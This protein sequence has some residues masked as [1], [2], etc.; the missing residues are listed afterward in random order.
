MVRMSGLNDKLIHR[1]KHAQHNP[2]LRPIETLS[3]VYTSGVKEELSKLAELMADVNPVEIVTAINHDAERDK[4]LEQAMQGK[5]TTPELRYNRALLEMLQQKQPTLAKVVPQLRLAMADLPHDPAGA[6][7]QKLIQAR[8]TNANLLLLAA[9]GIRRGSVTA[10][11]AAFIEIYGVPNRHLVK[12][13]QAIIEGQKATTDYVVHDAALLSRDEQKRLMAIKL[14]AEAVRRIFLWAAEQYGL[15]QTRPVLI[16]EG[17]TA[18]D[19]RDTA[20]DG[21]C[22]VIPANYEKPA[23]KIPQLV[24]HEIGCHWRDSENMKSLVPMLGSGALKPFDELFYEGHAVEAEYAI[25]LRAKGVVKDTLRLCYPIAI[26]LAYHNQF[27]FEETARA[28]YELLRFKHEA[29]E[30]TLREVWQA[31]Y[32]VYRGNPRMLMRSGYAFTKD[33]GY[34]TGQLLAHDLKAAGMACLLDYGTLSLKDLS[35]LMPV[36]RMQPAEEMP[37]PPKDLAAELYRRLLAGEFLN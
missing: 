23:L 33:R 9:D 22:V 20:R 11:K 25:D 19:V 37:Y 34:Y 24:A 6:A 17:V 7:L 35:V 29:R 3:E 14:G 26:Q 21:A 31:T 1:W 32:R 27:L 13:A 28:L 12:R 8:I 10:V 16:Q 30:T 4:W 2:E 36:F 15:A 18:V 5:F